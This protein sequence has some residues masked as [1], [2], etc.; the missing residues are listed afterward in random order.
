MLARTR[1]DEPSGD[2]PHLVVGDH[3]AMTCASTS[4]VRLF[5]RRPPVHCV[6]IGRARLHVEGGTL[7]SPGAIAVPAN[8]LHRLSLDGA[9][10]CVAYLD[11]RRYSFEDAA[12]LAERWRGFVP[13]QDD[14]REAVGDAVRSPPRGLDARLSVALGALEDPRTTVAAAAS[15]ARL[16]E[17]RLTHLMTETLGAPPRTW[18]AWLRLQRAIQAS[19]F[20]GAN[21]TEA[22]HHAGFADSAHLTRTCKQLTGVRPGQMMPKSVEVAT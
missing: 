7:V 1:A 13:G 20:G 15:R 11:P 17:S 16:S 10:A 9:H 5:E 19:V 2:G 14:L 21:L 12:R 22:A 18:R 6:L 3:V 4:G 8:T